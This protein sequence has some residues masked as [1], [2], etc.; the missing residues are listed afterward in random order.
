[1]VTQGTGPNLE[2]EEAR[3]IASRQG[4]LGDELGR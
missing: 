3:E 1:M 4:L 2:M